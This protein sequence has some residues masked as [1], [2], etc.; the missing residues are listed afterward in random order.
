MDDYANVEKGL[1]DYFEYNILM[2]PDE[3]NYSLFTSIGDKAYKSGREMA[4][5]SA[6]QVVEAPS[7]VPALRNPNY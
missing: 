6:V 2:D 3:V 5:R 4:C 7:P 1:K